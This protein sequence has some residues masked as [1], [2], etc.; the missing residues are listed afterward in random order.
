M[1]PRRPELKRR[2]YVGPETE[3]KITL[4][5]A[6]QSHLQETQQ[7]RPFSETSLGRLPGEIRDMIYEHILVALPSQQKRYLRVPDAAVVDPKAAEARKS[8]AAPLHKSKPGNASYV[9]ILATCRQIHREAYHVFYAKNA[10]HFTDAPV[11]IAFLKG[12]GQIRRAELTCLHLEGLVVDQAQWNRELLDI[13]CL[14]NNVDSVERQKL[15]AERCLDIHPDISPARELLNDCQNLSRLILEMRTCERFDYFSFLKTSLRRRRPVVYIVDNT[16]W[17][18]R[19]PCTEENEDITWNE[20]VTRIEETVERW[21]AHASAHPV[22]ETGGLQRVVV[23]IVRGPEEA[24]GKGYESWIA[25][26]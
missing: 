9:A 19:W 17:V 14:D 24:L 3:R 23:D 6:H 25:T 5:L 13:Y 15:E 18:V 8:P 16:R 20:E 10:F 21:F 12:I 4:M 22:E 26:S 2:K 1:P 11:L 7:Q